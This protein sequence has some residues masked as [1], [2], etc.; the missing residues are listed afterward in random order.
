MNMTY[1]SEWYGTAAETE[2]EVHNGSANARAGRIDSYALG[3]FYAG[4]ELTDNA[5]IKFGV[6]NFT[7]LEYI[8]TRHPQGARAGAPLTAY[9]RATVNY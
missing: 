6:N 4:Y 8:A 2:T 9:D 5:A 1:Q 7:D 3:N